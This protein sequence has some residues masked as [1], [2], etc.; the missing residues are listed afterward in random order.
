VGGDQ[1]RQG[2][3]DGAE[4][5][6]AHTHELFS[7]VIGEGAEVVGRTGAPI[8]PWFLVL[9]PPDHIVQ[10]GRERGFQ[11]KSGSIGR[12]PGER[13]PS[14]PFYLMQHFDNISELK[15]PEKILNAYNSSDNT[16]FILNKEQFEFLESSVTNLSYR[17][18]SSFITDRKEKSDYYVLIKK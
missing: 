12:T 14:L 17:N 1:R 10:R 16:A 4:P 8:Q 18:F 3:V 9:V 11:G 6:K 13:P 7:Q 5:L 15:E 2:G